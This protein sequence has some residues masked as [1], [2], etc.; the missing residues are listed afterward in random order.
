VITALNKEKA[1]EHLRD[2]ESGEHFLT[3]D[4]T[5]DNLIDVSNL[6]FGSISA[7]I[8]RRVMWE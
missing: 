6:P 2:F 3:S 8:A 4:Y 1:W 7:Y 5:P